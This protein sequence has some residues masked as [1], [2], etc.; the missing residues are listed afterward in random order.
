MDKETPDT[1]ALEVAY[2]LAR[3]KL[4]LGLQAKAMKSEFIDVAAIGVLIDEIVKKLSEFSAIKT[5]L[6][7][8]SSAIGNAQTQIDD[9]KADLASKLEEL[10]EKAKPIVKK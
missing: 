6:T 4:L 10:T 8:A 9:M 1:T 7:K 5:T 3:T 2:K